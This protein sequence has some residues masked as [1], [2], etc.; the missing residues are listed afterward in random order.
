MARSPSANRQKG[1]A[2]KGA[3][4]PN[5]RV[6]AVFPGPPMLHAVRALEGKLEKYGNLTRA[7]T[8]SKTGART[9]LRVWKAAAG[10]GCGKLL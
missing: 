1:N 9:A 3:G 5:D 2:R 6:L 10:G 8:T 4:S 7:A